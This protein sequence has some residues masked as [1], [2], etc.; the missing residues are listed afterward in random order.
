MRVCQVSDQLESHGCEQKL[1]KNCRPS[2]SFVELKD[3]ARYRVRGL[4]H[5]RASRRTKA[6]LEAAWSGAG[7]GSLFGC[8]LHILRGL[9]SVR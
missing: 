6:A 3:Q 1:D 9:Q 2:R 8:P 5:G 4:V 7:I